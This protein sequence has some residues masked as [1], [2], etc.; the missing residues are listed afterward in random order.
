MHN[1]NDEY[2]IVV[3]VDEICV[4][5]LLISCEYAHIV[6]NECETMLLLIV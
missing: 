5:M 6:M 4:R 3:Y 2:V 1:V